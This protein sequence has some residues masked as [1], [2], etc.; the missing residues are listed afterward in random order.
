MEPFKYTTRIKGNEIFLPDAVLEKISPDKEVEII[1]RAISF[2]KESSD[3]IDQ[4]LEKTFADINQ[5]YP[6]LELEI[7]KKLK[8]VAGIS[9][10]Q[11]SR[12][13]K[14]SDKEIASMARME[15]Y[16]EKEEILESLY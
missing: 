2:P 13:R 16:M 11:N 7:N 15:K 8:A 12:W 3:G 14:F 1:V 10:S 6:N 5:K 9:C 4:V